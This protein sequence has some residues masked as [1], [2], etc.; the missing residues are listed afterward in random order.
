MEKSETNAIFALMDTEL[1]RRTEELNG[2]TAIENAAL[3]TLFSK[4]F[5]RRSFERVYSLT[6]IE[7]VR[8]LACPI[9]IRGGE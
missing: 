9:R 4:L 3:E 6:A 8:K 2:K 5:E 7:F 1:R